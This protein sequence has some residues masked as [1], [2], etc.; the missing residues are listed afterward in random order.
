MCP[1]Y[2]AMGMTYEEYWDKECDMAPAFREAYR[3]RKEDE[4]RAAWLQGMYVYEAICDASPILHAFAR[5]G[6]RAHPYAKEPYEYIKRRK[7]KAEKNAEKTQKTVE[8]MQKM[9]A[10]FNQNFEKKQK[11]KELNAMM[12]GNDA[13]KPTE[14]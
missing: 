10:M 9:A 4:N 7:T 3:L 1:Q 14:T 5:S 11:E 12:Q 2:M 8:Y 13:D 6:T